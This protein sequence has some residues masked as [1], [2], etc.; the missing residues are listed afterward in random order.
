MPARWAQLQRAL[1]AAAIACGG[2]GAAW[3]SAA[4]AK[5]R[6]TP[7]YL[8]PH[9]LTT[10][11]KRFKHY[12]SHDDASGRHLMRPEQFVRSMLCSR[13]RTTPI[14]PAAVKDVEE[15]FRVVDADGDGAL[16]FGEYVLFMT[17]LTT[18]R[19]RFELACAVFDTDGTGTIGVEEFKE[20]VYAVTRDDSARDR[21]AFKGGITDAFF[22]PEHDRRIS[23]EEFW[24]F[25]SSLRT[26]VWRAEFRMFDEGCTGEVTHAEF[27]RLAWGPMVGS[28]LP[29]FLV[30]NIRR[31]EQRGEHHRVS[32][33]A[34]EGLNALMLDAEQIALCIHTYTASG[35]PLTKADFARAV[36]YVQPKNPVTGHKELPEAQRREIG[37]IFDLI[38]ALFD[39]DGVGNLEPDEFL[40]FARARNSFNAGASREGEG[41]PIGRLVL[42]CA[43]QAIEEQRLTNLMR[44]S[45]D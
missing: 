11:R 9:Y 18:P 15:L 37:V 43:W 2:A 8:L 17:F 45:F 14:T 26:T 36:K 4:H 41:L 39:K 13:K 40:S 1:R 44:L 27:A 19:R 34:W 29:F 21:I 23:F 7:D 10:F 28:H 30:K 20:V 35:M 24:S 25:V 3:G 31:L 33:S 16:T 22:G 42:K 38:F 5:A 32:L 6:D 12:S